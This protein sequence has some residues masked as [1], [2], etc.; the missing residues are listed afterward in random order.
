AS[1][2]KALKI[3]P[4]YHE[5]WHFLGITLRNLERYEDA[6][7][8][9][10]KA[11]KIKPDYH[12]AWN[13][14]GVALGYLGRYEERIASYDK[15]LEIKPDKHNTWLNRGITAGE[16]IS[17]N[18]FLAS[19]STIARQ[20]PALNQRGYEGKLA[21][22][23]EG[24]KYCHQ[25]T[26]P[27]GWGI[28]HQAM[29]KAH[30]FQGKILQEREKNPNY[31]QYWDKA[32]TEYKQ[33]LVTLTSGTFPE[34][35]L[36]VL[37]D[38]I[39]VLFGLAKDNEAKQWRKQGL[40]IFKNLLNSPDKSSFQKRQ[41]RAKFSDFSQMRVDVLIEDGD[42]VPALEAAERNKNF[43]LTWILDNQKEHILSPSYREIQRLINPQ[44]APNTA[45]IYWHISPF[46]LSTFIIKPD[47]NRPIVIPTQ[48]PDELKAWVKD[49]DKQYENYREGKQQQQ[50]NPTW[51]DN[52]PELLERLS[53]ILNIS[54]I[55]ESIQNP[56]S[57]IQTSQIKIQNLILIPHRDLHRFP[58]HALFTDD[59]SINYLPSA[60]IGTNLQQKLVVS[61]PNSFLS[62]ESPDSKESDGKEFTDLPHAEVESATICGMFANPQRL[63]RNQVSKKNLKRA[64]AHGY[65]IFHFTGHA[66]YNY[67]KP[68]LSCLA[69]SGK[70][71]LTSEDITHTQLPLYKYQMVSLSACETAIT[72]NQ[73]IDDEYVGLVSAFL[74]QGVTNVL[75]TLWT[76]ESVSSALFM[77]EFYRQPDWNI[78]P[79]VAL[80]RTQI[81]LRNV[82]YKELV[83]WYKQRAEE[84]SKKDVTC[85]EDLLDEAEIIEGDHTKINKTVPPYAH[86]YYWAA[87]IITGKIHS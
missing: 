85:A 24:L 46:A 53:E 76:V 8:S 22:Y 61:H 18:Q 50:P 78:T 81:W 48:K 51:R 32:E 21:S 71:R 7:A 13:N 79:A 43:Y 26:H 17:V 67:H 27:E 15:A 70:D 65:K 52:L 25:N 11:L 66:T 60:Q 9:Y 82:T 35:H 68:Q 14:R 38:L 28:L 59:F 34:L 41:L 64:L 72:G 63:I 16:S 20:N 36:K 3:K 73:T 69:L 87:F 84:I 2:D 37:Q 39:C 23:L 5:A 29:G 44:T 30:Y 77:I 42:F 54:H 75:S 83:N 80:K 62:V 4:D 55:I 12:E 1:Y 47:T 31:H 57:N 10:D 6:I 86:P 56:S 33:A 40:N 19:S 49:W 74:S 45:I 58:L